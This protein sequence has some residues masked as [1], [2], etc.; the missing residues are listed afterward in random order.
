MRGN[1]HRDEGEFVDILRGFLVDRPGHRPASKLIDVCRYLVRFLAEL[2][3]D[4]RA[5]VLYLIR[6]RA[7]Y[8]D[9]FGFSRAGWY[10]DDLPAPCSTSYSVGSL[11]KLLP[12]RCEGSGT[13]LSPSVCCS[14][15]VHSV[16]IGIEHLILAL[17]RIRKGPPAFIPAGPI[18]KVPQLLLK[19][20]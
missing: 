20:S 7:Q 5:G 11:Y 15:A 19:I 12:P 10:Q 8:F 18:Q 16:C 14:M 6:Y 13:W 17:L 4:Q 2:G 3:H 9:G 1:K